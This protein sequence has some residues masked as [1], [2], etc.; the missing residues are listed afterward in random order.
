M[1]GTPVFSNLWQLYTTL[2]APYLQ[3]DTRRTF[4]H[5]KQFLLSG[6]PDKPADTYTGLELLQ[7]VQHAVEAGRKPNGINVNL[8]RLHNFGRW[9]ERQKLLP[10]DN[11]FS[12]VELLKVP[13]VPIRYLS[14]E[15]F[16][17]IFQAEKSK[18]MRSVFL[19]A[20][21]TGQRLSDICRLQW[22][23][24]DMSHMVLRVRNTKSN[25]LNVLPLHPMLMEV[26]HDLGVRR[27]GPLFD[28]TYTASYVSHRFLSAA[29]KAKVDD[30][31]FHTLRKTFASWLVLQ[32]VELHQI[33]KLL[34]HASVTLTERYHAALVASDMHGQVAKLMPVTGSIPIQTG[35]SPNPFAR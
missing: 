7:L 18:M 20:L 19:V 10:P 17:Q 24:V 12:Q 9:C 14:H 5:T 3:P 34:G 27:A 25:R 11:P 22:E 23:N 6:L 4:A 31:T 8:R 1:T 30:A 16:R 13:R 29:R 33:Q 35:P 21:L 32:G 15:E 26:L 2:R 28:K